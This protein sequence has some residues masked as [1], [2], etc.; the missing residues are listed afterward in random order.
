[1]G[2][3]RK[4]CRTFHI[5]LLKLRIEREEMSLWVS[6]EKVGESCKKEEEKEIATWKEGTLIKIKPKW[7]TELDGKRK[8]E[9]DE[10][11]REFK[12]VLSG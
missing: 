11:L 10:V 12:D 8:R 2:E 5:N 6:E 3:R 7:G 9:M 1:M 4:K